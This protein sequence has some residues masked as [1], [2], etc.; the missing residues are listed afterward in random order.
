MPKN[1]GN[2][3]P[4]KSDGTLSPKAV[5]VLTGIAEGRTYEQILAT[6]PDLSYPDVFA[7]AREALELAASSRPKDYHARL[8]DIKSRHRRAYE[9]WSQAEDDE[10]RS[11]V[12][13]GA[14]V[15]DIAEDL[16]RQQGAIQ[17]RLSKLEIS[18][19]ADH[20]EASQPEHP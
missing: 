3:M 15:H 6:A 13:S 18:S 7:A 19:Q 8:R 16:Q 1:E 10:L 11:L 12:A 17:S 2:A 9:P 14:S 20:T 5:L 4:R